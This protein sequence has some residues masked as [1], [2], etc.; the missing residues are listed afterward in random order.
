MR[1][2]TFEE[3]LVDI[4]R[5]FLSAQLLIEVVEVFQLARINTASESV[6]AVDTVGVEEIVEAIQ[7]ENK[8]VEPV[9]I[10][11]KIVVVIEV[12]K[13]EKVGE[14]DE[15]VEVIYAVDVVEYAETVGQKFDTCYSRKRKNGIKNFEVK[16]CS[17]QE[18]IVERK[19]YLLR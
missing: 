11:E 5:L 2:M 3:A 15:E 1:L 4:H 18:K 17:S 9:D 16:A 14:F 7:L 12:E 13:M 19:I 10:I 8:V 6:K